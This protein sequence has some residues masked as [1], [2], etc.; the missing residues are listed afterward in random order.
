MSGDRWKRHREVAEEA[1]RAAG[2]VLREHLGHVA[3]EYKGAI[4][5]VTEA[6]REAE[7]VIISRIRAAF[8]EHGFLAEESGRDK[9]DSDWVWLIDPLDGTTNYAH[10]LPLFAVSIALQAQGELVIGVVYDPLRDELFSAEKGN[11]AWLNET[12]LK[13]SDQHQLQRSLLVTGFPYSI[14]E[15]D[16]HNLDHFA[17]FLMEAQAV[18]R[19]G[20]AAIDL[21]YVAAGRM[22]GYWEVS[23]NAWD[24]AAGALLVTEAGGRVTDLRGRPF[25][26]EGRQILAT[27]GHLHEPM[28]AVLQRG[29]TGM[30]HEG[31]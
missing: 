20:S 19:L 17:N 22:D 29:R 2:Q 16:H 30:G 14:K 7:R 3:V 6:D 15:T 18:R 9:A 27:N 8:P 10:G 26:V 1:A 31:A 23:L 28:L 12:P 21:A 24:M 11:G 25:H 4:D 13:V 5:L